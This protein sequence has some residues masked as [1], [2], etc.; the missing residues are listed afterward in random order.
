MNSIV[1]VGFTLPFPNSFAADNI[2]ASL[3]L[4]WHNNCQCLRK[5][6]VLGAR[7]GL[8]TSQHWHATQVAML[9]YGVACASHALTHLA[10]LSCA[11]D[12]LYTDFTIN[13]VRWVW[14]AWM[15]T[16]CALLDLGQYYQV[17]CFFRE[18]HP[19]ICSS[20]VGLNNVVMCWCVNL[21]YSG[22]CFNVCV[23]ICVLNSVN[24]LD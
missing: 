23:A 6:S 12:H 14:V 5:S 18:F 17:W 13:V 21:L 19:W 3:S 11:C 9:F 1:F 7:T 4:G 16:P 15:V 20:K 24:C 22:N 10:M 8:T 2:Q